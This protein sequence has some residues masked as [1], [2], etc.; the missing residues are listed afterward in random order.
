M[1][2]GETAAGKY[3]VEAVRTMDAIARKTETNMRGGALAPVALG[4]AHLSITAATAHAACTTAIDIGADAVLTVGQAGI[5]AQIVS[6]FR[7][8]T[9]IVALLLDEQVQRRELALYWGVEPITMPRASS[10]DELVDLAVRSAERQAGLVR[11]GDLVVVTAGVPVGISGTTNMI[12]VQQVGGSL[13]N[14]VGIGTQQ[15]SGPLCVC[16][17]TDE[18]PQKFRSGDVLVVP[19]TTNDVLAVSARGGGDHQ[20]GGQPRLPH[21]DGG[22]SARKARPARRDGC[23]AAAQR[24]G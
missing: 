11:R 5:T 18:V 13:V 14:A 19:Y 20:R 17:T 23:D 3:P 21:G 24:T 22:A 10:S 15:T 7:P 9:L 8:D 16:R 2:S 12:R 6:R 1:L 4:K